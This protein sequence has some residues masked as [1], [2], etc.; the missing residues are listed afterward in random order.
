MA[1]FTGVIAHS[2]SK[3]VF[4]NAP[5]NS[6]ETSMPNKLLLRGRHTP[7][8]AICA[9]FSVTLTTQ[10]QL[11]G[12]VTVDPTPL[13]TNPALAALSAPPPP[14]TP[15]NVG[16]LGGLTTPA[17]IPPPVT[18]TG[19]RMST[20]TID[21][22]A[23]VNGAIW[24]IATGDYSI[25]EWNGKDFIKMKALGTGIPASRI[26]LSPGGIPFVVDQK[27][28]IYYYDPV[29]RV[30]NGMPGAAADIGIGSEGS[31]WIVSPAGVVQKWDGK[32]WQTAGTINDAVARRIAVDPF[33]SPWVIGPAG[34]YHYNNGAF[35]KLPFG[36]N[37]IAI[38]ADGA[39]WVPATEPGG[40]GR[41]QW[42]N[43]QKLIQFEGQKAIA[44]AVD[45][46][47]LGYAID[48]SLNLFRLALPGPVP[49]MT[50]IASTSW[51]S[52]P[53]KGKMLCSAR[54]FP[55][56][57][58]R[59]LATFVGSY[60][61]STKCSS[62][63]YDPIWG[64]S[65]WKC[66]EDTDSNGGW[67]RSLDPVTSS[68]ACWR[69]PKTETFAAAT[70]VAANTA[71]Y[72]CPA[73]SFWD[74]FGGGNGGCWSCPADRPR[75]TAYAI[76]SPKACASSANETKSAIFLTYNGCPTPDRDSLGFTGSKMPGRPFPDIGA[77]GCF[78][79]PVV[80]KDGTLLIP[81]RNGIGLYKQ[82]TETEEPYASTIDKAWGCDVAF[83][84]QP[85]PY[86]QPGLAGMAGTLE[87]IMEK[88]IFEF[89]DLMTGYLYAL[90]DARD[91]KGADA[92][93]YVQQAWKDLALDPINSGALRALGYLL[94]QG[95]VVK[96]ASIR[97]PA[98]QKL[99]ASFAS[100]IVNR[101]V[102]L[103]QQG[104]DMY[105][106]WKANSDSIQAS[107]AKGP[108][109][110]AFGYGVVPLDFK[111]MITALAGTLSAP[112]V[113][114]V[115]LAAAYNKAMAMHDA[116]LDNLDKIAGADALNAPI[117]F[118]PVETASRFS[119]LARP[120]AAV[121]TQLDK[122]VTAVRSLSATTMFCLSGVILAE[123]ALGVLLGIASQQFLA[124]ETARPELL[125]LR[126]AAA[127]PVDVSTLM[128]T[129]DG[130][131][132]ALLYW[133]QAMEVKENTIL[134]L[135]NMAQQGQKWAEVR[136]YLR[137]KGI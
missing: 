71:S 23:A 119:R 21:V 130:R 135:T 131:S 114:S 134:G 30:W 72:N 123:I 53:T 93:A 122:V 40:A 84:Y 101:R 49:V 136:K 29:Q 10:A 98:E 22:A 64:G 82:D 133:G 13:A 126:D 37:D 83:R 43:G 65:C 67:I 124:I 74:G 42:W 2:H 62:G 51:L 5:P 36:G 125:A 8:V 16:L 99:I 27:N 55:N 97:T 69:A 127:Q 108:I 14:L 20:L 116:A 91:L 25:W 102:Y 103:A 79:C 75:R 90:A 28:A 9:M 52:S 61:F 34:A 54:E 80:A 39:V 137:P 77:G 15:Q 117:D 106:A 46:L 7:F 24:V 18:L 57:C 32:A 60:T 100:Y 115:G 104:L 4:D 66:P 19:T 59:A 45:G 81:S 110:Q 120:F 96:D 89:P 95:A 70:S 121:S 109:A 112:S 1:L 44:L 113:T 31:I 12:P 48:A 85:A 76:D 6:K 47:G 92:T 26:A 88:R 107:L 50:G 128:S 105:D 68:T 73:G 87:V 35:E 86:W 94:L 111:G 17:P 41:L 58:G 3:G 78:V 129:E 56:E 33:G 132:Q 11:V 63:F 38:G 118:T